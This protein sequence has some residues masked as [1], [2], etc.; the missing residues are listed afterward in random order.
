MEEYAA[1][2]LKLVLDKCPSDSVSEIRFIS[3]MSPAFVDKEGPHFVEIAYLSKEVVGEIHELCRSLADEPVK[4]SGATSTYT[5]VLR[6]FGRLLCKYQ[7]RGNVASLIMERDADAEET[8]DAIR[9]RKRPSLRAQ[10]KPEPKRKG[11]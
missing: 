11:H 8:I 6:R 4:G 5:F 1:K 7:R 10:A 3:G 9:P 2:L